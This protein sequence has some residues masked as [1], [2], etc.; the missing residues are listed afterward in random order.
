MLSVEFTIGFGFR[1]AGFAWISNRR[2]DSLPLVVLIGTCGCLVFFLSLSLNGNER[3]GIYYLQALMSIF[4]FSTL[5]HDFWRAENRVNLAKYWL[6]LLTIV[7]GISA[8]SGFLIGFV[9]IATHHTPGIST[10]KIKLAVSV[11]A[12]FASA[13]NFSLLKRKNSPVALATAVILVAAMGFSGW[14]TPWLNYAMGRARRDIIV[15]PAEVRGL[16]RLNQISSP[17]DLFATNKH[18]VDSLVSNRERSY[19]Y[20]TL[21]LRPVLLEG[22]L[23]HGI[24]DVP[25]FPR[26]LHDNDLMFTT[27]DSQQL[28][29]LVDQ[30]RVKWLVAR[31]GTDIGLKSLP[32]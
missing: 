7:C 24:E 11:A 14:I 5:S 4:A 30:Y 6:K 22:Y 2:K 29:N 17:H 12:F 25:S 31:P 27:S 18:A 15:A 10:F 1:L 3:Y 13:V 28:R 8:I 23:D 21:S 9:A 20:S 16:Q 26:L 32:P 19:A